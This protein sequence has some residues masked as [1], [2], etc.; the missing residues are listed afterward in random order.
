MNVYFILPTSSTD[1][2]GFLHR[3]ILLESPHHISIREE[4]IHEEQSYMYV[5]R[6]RSH[7]VRFTD[8]DIAPVRCVW[9]A[10]P[11]TTTSAILIYFFKIDLGYRS[12]FRG[13]ISNPSFSMSSIVCM[14]I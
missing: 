14:M 13:I 3:I 9:N 10:V 4:T 11:G 2:F 1:R 7:F 8:F 6:D 12:L 5:R